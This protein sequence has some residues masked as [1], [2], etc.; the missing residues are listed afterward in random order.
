MMNSSF[1]IFNNSLLIFSFFFFFNFEKRI[2]YGIYV[3]ALYVI[4]IRRCL[5]HEGNESPHATPVSYYRHPKRARRQ[6][7]SPGYL[8]AS[9]SRNFVVVFIGRRCQ[10]F[11]DV[12][13]FFLA[14]ARMLL[15]RVVDQEKPEYVPYRKS[16][17]ILCK[18]AME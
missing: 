10:T 7:R 14:Y 5:C 13:F 15:G 16:S 4:E 6:Y 11:D 18:I 12:V 2:T 9:L 8:F 1:S 3:P 17:F